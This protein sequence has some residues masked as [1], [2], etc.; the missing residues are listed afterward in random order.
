MQE[1]SAPVTTLYR[2]FDESGILLYIGIADAPVTRFEQHGRSSAWAIYTSSLTFS[3]Y[4]DREDCLLAEKHAVRHE[5]PVYNIVHAGTNETRVASYLEYRHVRGLFVI[6]PTSPVGRP[7]RQELKNA[8]ADLDRD[9]VY[10][11]FTCPVCRSAPGARCR[12]AARTT[13]DEGH[14]ARRAFISS[15]I[16]LARL[17]R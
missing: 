9:W 1:P 10:M 5:D 16:R 12:G 6:W 3:S 8:L 11:D 4:T 13:H 7:W 14:M 15:N 2:S 17:N